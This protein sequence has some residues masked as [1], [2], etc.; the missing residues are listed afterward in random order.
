M[1]NGIKGMVSILKLYDCLATVLLCWCLTNI[2]M[3]FGP[4]F[5]QNLQYLHHAI[6]ALVNTGARSHFCTY[7]RWLYG[8][9]FAFLG[10]EA[11]Y[12]KKNL[13]HFLG[14]LIFWCKHPAKGRHRRDF[15]ARG[16]VQWCWPVL[17]Q[18]YIPDKG[19]FRYWGSRRPTSV[20]G[21]PLL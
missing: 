2:P 5:W 10:P 9:L 18:Y 14:Y 7:P 16:L 19:N 3:K 11:S 13:L 21:V 17:Q 4:L 12:H 20:V 1:D 15:E 6:F 8:M